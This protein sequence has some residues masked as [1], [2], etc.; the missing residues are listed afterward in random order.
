MSENFVQL[1]ENSFVNLNFKEGEII[2]GKVLEVGDDFVIVDSGLKSESYIPKKQFINLDGELTVE[3]GGYIEVLL[4]SIENGY[5]GTRLSREKAIASQSWEY[6]EQCIETGKIIKCK[7]VSLLRAGLMID[8]NGINGFLPGSLV[9]I[10]PVKDFTVFENQILELKVI[11]IDRER[12]SVV[13]SR[14]AVLEQENFAQRAEIIANMEEGQIVKGIVKNIADY[15]VF[16]DLG[17]IDGLLH[18]TDMAWRRVTNPRDMV[19]LGDEVTVKILSFDKQKNRV[20]LGMKQLSNDPWDNILEKYAPDSVYTGKVSKI[21]DY[22]AFVELEDGI[23]GLV[24]LSE[25]DWVNKNPYPSKIVSI[26][27]EIEVKILEIDEDKHRMSMSIKQIIPN[28]WDDFANKFK[29][30]DKVKGPIKSITDFGLFI[31]LEGG[32][33]G[34]IHVSDLSWNPNNQDLLKEYKKGDEVEAIILVIDTEKERVALGIKQLASDDFSAFATT[35]SKNSSVKVTVTSVE[36]DEYRVQLEDNIFASLSK[37]DVV[38]ELKVGDVVEA[39]IKDIDKKTRNIV[40]SVKALKNKE[41]KNAI[42]EYSK[43]QSSTAKNTI[44]DLLEQKDK[45]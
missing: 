23:E 30:S 2:K 18:I 44:G 19:N 9:D 34:L 29:Q 28:P 41:E 39:L 36:E 15:G 7:V 31:G 38:E 1:L 5:G 26:G 14:K 43:N 16:I 32:I 22:G 6:L 13:V 25:F 3:E 37:K 35:N 40:V 10:K 45:E 33:D 8:V 4:E 17:N 11:K 12:D 27:Q 24:H 21:T 42:K 20:A